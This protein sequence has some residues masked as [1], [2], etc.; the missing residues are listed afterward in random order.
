MRTEPV[1]FLFALYFQF[2]FLLSITQTKGFSCKFCMI[3]EKRGMIFVMAI[4]WEYIEIF[5]TKWLSN[6]FMWK[7]LQTTSSSSIDLSLICT[8]LMTRL[9]NS[10]VIVDIK[11]KYN[12]FWGKKLHLWGFFHVFSSPTWAGEDLKTKQKVTSVCVFQNLCACLIKIN[13]TPCFDN[14]GKFAGFSNIF[15]KRFPYK[16]LLYL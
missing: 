16:H 4:P 6:V 14:T 9:L 11:S 10:V 1:S 7:Y 13:Y 12:L 8:L 15:Y 2:H 3:I 5:H